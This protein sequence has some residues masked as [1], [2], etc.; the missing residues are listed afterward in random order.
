MQATRPRT[1]LIPLLSAGALAGLLTLGAWGI[2]RHTRPRDPMYQGR[3]L[4]TWVLELRLGDL[5]R[6]RQAEQAIRSLGPAAVPTLIRS[7]SRN[8]PLLKRGLLALR[9]SLPQATWRWLCGLVAPYDASYERMC[10]AQ[11]VDLLGP[12]AEAAVPALA[13]L[14]RQPRVGTAETWLAAGALADIGPAGIPPLIAA[15]R[16]GNLDTQ[17][18]ACA[19]LAQAGSRAAPAAGLLVATLDAPDTGL[20]AQASTALGRIGAPAL[21]ALFD[22]ILTVPGPTPLRLIQALANVGASSHEALQA[23]LAGLRHPKDQVRV[24]AVRAVALTPPL[25]LPSVRAVIQATADPDPAVR[26]A[27]VEALGDMAGR[28]P[29]ATNAVPA[30]RTRLQD[31]ESAIRQAAATVL[32]KLARPP[33]PRPPAP[34]P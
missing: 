4:R 2:I 20:Q 25:V 1:W 6:R 24:A 31:P 32:A 5:S 15:L 8:D 33:A 23:L 9:P 19:A 17:R 34:T 26:R 29:L 27:A 16:D 7:V 14:L 22:R 30:L 3:P 10:G 21:P 11:G 13:W 28:T 12:Q 18:V